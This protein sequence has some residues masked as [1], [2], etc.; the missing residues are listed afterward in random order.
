MKN[1]K[2]ITGI[3]ITA[4]L[5][6]FN[7]AG[8]NDTISD[9]STAK[10]TELVVMQ[11]INNETLKEEWAPETSIPS[12][13]PMQIGVR[14]TTQG[15]N[16]TTFVIIVKGPSGNEI[17]K[18]QRNITVNANSFE[19][20]IGIWSITNLSNVNITASVEVHAIDDKGNLSNKLTRSFTVTP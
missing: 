13:S 11:S 20:V 5:V 19:Y 7:M 18:D 1:R 6:M 17:L 9:I 10:L 16:I 4:L 8:C 15:D 14:G 12:D 2:K 3:I